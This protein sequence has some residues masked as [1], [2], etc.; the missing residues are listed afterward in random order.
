MVE[1]IHF[2]KTNQEE[3]KAIWGKNYA[4]QT[5]RDSTRLSGLYVR[6]PRQSIADA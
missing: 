2:N 1:A 4:S 3:A 5:R 6:L